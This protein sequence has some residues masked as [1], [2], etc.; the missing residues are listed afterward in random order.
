M[1]EYNKVSNLRYTWKIVKCNVC[2]REFLVERVLFGFDHTMDTLVTCKECL[3]K[4]G[5]PAKFKK[6]HPKEA[7]K[8]ERWLKGSE[9]E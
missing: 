4:K 8:I 5:I 7:E 9:N 2:G 6:E 3:K 1:T